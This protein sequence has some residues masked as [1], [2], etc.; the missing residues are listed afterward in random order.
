M[1]SF[2]RNLFAQPPAPPPQPAKTDSE[3]HFNQNFQVDP[4]KFLDEIFDDDAFKRL[5][6]EDLGGARVEKVEPSYHLQYNVT[7][8]GPRWPHPVVL[9]VGIMP[10]AFCMA[11]PITVFKKANPMLRE[12]VRTTGQAHTWDHSGAVNAFREAFRKIE[13]AAKK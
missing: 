10:T 6:A 7:V 2:F 8:A 11:V 9:F 4:R 5:L 3:Y 12:T 13:E 1:F